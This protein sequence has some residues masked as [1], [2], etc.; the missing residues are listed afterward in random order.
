[1]A[2]NQTC[3]DYIASYGSLDIG[4]YRIVYDD[5]KEI[6]EVKWITSWGPTKAFTMCTIKP[7]GS[8]L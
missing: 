7:Y 4:L 3:M 2:A 6:N 8:F 5:K 1:M